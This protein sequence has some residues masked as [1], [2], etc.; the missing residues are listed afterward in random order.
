MPGHESLSVLIVFFNRFLLSRREG[1]VQNHL[2]SERSISPARGLKCPH[3]GR[4]C[5]GG[6]K[7][8]VNTTRWDEWL[9]LHYSPFFVN[10]DKHADI[11]RA[12]QKTD[13]IRRN[14][15]SDLSQWFGRLYGRGCDRRWTERGAGGW[16][17]GGLPWG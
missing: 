9:G 5:C 13:N 7:I 10:R 8:L 11:N 1:K 15:G 12:S 6:S 2:A 14:N 16:L 4:T 3:A 17:H